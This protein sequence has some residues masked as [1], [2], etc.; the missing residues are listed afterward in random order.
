MNVF[1]VELV[2]TEITAY[3]FIQP[4]QNCQTTSELGQHGKWVSMVTKTPSWWKK[5]CEKKILI[6]REAVKH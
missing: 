3:G 5:Q 1:I 4:C 6:E 2:N